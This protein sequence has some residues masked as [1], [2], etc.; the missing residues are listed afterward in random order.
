MSTP[1]F[2]LNATRPAPPANGQNINWQFDNSNPVVNV[3]AYVALGGSNTGVQVNSNGVLYADSNFTWDHNARVLTIS[4]VSSSGIFI[5]SFGNLTLQGLFTTL[6]G[7]AGGIL[8]ALDPPTAAVVGYTIAVNPGVSNKAAIGHT[9]ANQW[10]FDDSTGYTSWGGVGGGRAAI[11]YAGATTP[12]TILLPTTTGAAGQVLTTNGGNPQQLTWM[13]TG[14]GSIGGS[15]SNLEVAVGTGTN[16]IGGSSNLTYNAAS[17]LTVGATS[18]SAEIVL[19]PSTGS[20]FATALYANTD[21]SFQIAPTVGASAQLTLNQTGAIISATNTAA[22]QLNFVGATSGAASLGVTAIAGSPNRINLPISTG[23]AGQALVTN[24]G[25]P[26]QTSWAT[27]ATIG[28]TISATQVAYG[29][30]TNTI[31]SNA[32]FTW[33]NGLVISQVALGDTPI[34]IDLLF[35]SGTLVPALIL[36]NSGATHPFAISRGDSIPFNITGWYIGSSNFSGAYIALPDVGGTSSMEFSNPVSNLIGQSLT[37]SPALALKQTNISTTAIAIQGQTSGTVFIQV[38]ANAGSSNPLQLPTA[39]GTAGQVLTTNGGNPQQ[40][41]WSTSNVPPGPPNS[42]LVAGNSGGPVTTEL[43]TA[44]TYAILG[45][46]AVTNSD[47][48]STAISGGN[49]GSFPTNTITPGTPPWTLSGGTA[50]VTATSQNQADLNT[51]IVFYQGLASTPLSSGYSTTTFTATATGYNG[52]PG[53]VGNASS[54]L[55]FSGGIITLN[56]A[57]FSNPVFVFQVGSGLNVNTSLTTFNLINGASAAN[58]VWVVGSS[59]VFTAQTGGNWAG[60]I[61]AVT[62]ITLAGG[63]LNGRAL[64]NN[65]AV[66]ISVATTIIVPAE[67]TP[68]FST[69]PTVVSLTTT[70][71]NLTGVGIVEPGAI[72]TFAGAGSPPAEGEINANFLYGVQIS[73]TAPTAGQV[74]TATSATSANWQAPSSLA[75]GTP[76]S[77]SNIVISA[78]WGLAGGS[79]PTPGASATISGYNSAFTITITSGDVSL[80]ANPTF[81]VTFADGAFANV[82]I[83]L[84][85]QI[86]GTDTISFVTIMPSTTGAVFTWNSTPAPDSTYIFNVLVKGLA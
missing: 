24:G 16:T 34:T 86:G 43:G 55:L 49:I 48:A 15:I 35:N 27:I 54:T 8:Q 30:G 28:S 46:S 84:C 67:G 29:S 62:S 13:S 61:L 31:T 75:S 17:G 72:L 18:G 1:L 59:A 37:T 78:G 53:F 38:A 42:V 19:T 3:S 50:V 41:Y 56:G 64:A 7:G 51:A 79:P 82:P 47:G 65:G 6:T 32:D 2:N 80:S 33:N 60:N 73:G 4:G 70:N 20:N 66:T 76:L 63:T 23:T 85:Q 74:L 40:L 68:F 25:S 14:A 45:A 36:N 26:Q 12:N 77:N 39:S 5:D 11:G 52:G 57:G 71:F 81:T 9:T 22:T 69:T 58:V 10:I 83:I 21:G 44:G